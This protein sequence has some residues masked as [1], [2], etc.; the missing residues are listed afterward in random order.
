MIIEPKEWWRWNFC[1]Q[2]LSLVLQLESNFKFVCAIENKQLIA[3]ANSPQA[4][5][6]D[7]TQLYYQVIDA[8]QSVE[9]SDPIKVQVALNYI[10]NK[11]FHRPLMPQSWFFDLN[12]FGYYQPKGIELVEMKGQFYSPAT[13]LLVDGKAR[14]LVGDSNNNTSTLMLIDPSLQLKSGKNLASFTQIKV[15]NDRV[16]PLTLEPQ[17]ASQS[18]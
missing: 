6:L 13:G 7:D 15:M 16:F 1:R 11:K 9:L 14:F 5:N 12:D 8:L 10:A 4:F 18:A 2:E 3:S 17:M